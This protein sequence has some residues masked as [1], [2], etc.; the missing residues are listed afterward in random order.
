M[1]AFRIEADL[2]RANEAIERLSGQ[3][4]HG[5]RMLVLE[6]MA[7]TMQLPLTYIKTVFSAGP[8][9]AETAFI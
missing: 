2:R 3:K 5:Y 1:S 9:K 8:T 4:A 6:V 7:D